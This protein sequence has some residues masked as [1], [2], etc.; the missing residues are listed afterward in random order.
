MGN[1]LPIQCYDLKGNHLKT[2]YRYAD[3]I[4]FCNWQTKTGVWV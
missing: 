1:T 4:K 3:A 2:F